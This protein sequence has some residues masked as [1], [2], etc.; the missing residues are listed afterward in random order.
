MVMTYKLLTIK[1]ESEKRC[2][3][4]HL[5]V[6][7]TVL[8]IEKQITK[9]SNVKY[10]FYNIQQKKSDRIVV[11]NTMNPM[12]FIHLNISMMREI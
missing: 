3:S 4:K 9:H 1:H 11:Q 2:F 8:L 10:A 7:H 12:E 5:S 6:R